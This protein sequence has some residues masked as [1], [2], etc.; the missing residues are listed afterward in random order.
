MTC[1]VDD[2]DGDRVVMPQ[3][4]HI[5]VDVSD[6]VATISITRAGRGNSLTT[7]TYLELRE[8]VRLAEVDDG[9]EIIVFS[10]E[11]R[12]FATGGDLDEA[13]VK[14]E[15]Q[16]ILAIHRGFDATPFAAIQ[17][18][19]KV[20]IA[21]VN[22]ICVAGGLMIAL[23]CDICIAAEDARFGIPEGRV[24]LA[25]PWFP[26][27]LEASPNPSLARFLMLSG[28]PFDVET[29]K[30]V[31]I[32]GESVAP[33]ALMT[34]VAELTAELRMTTVGARR[35]YKRFMNG[36]RPIVTTERLAHMM[37]EPDVIE[38]LR[39]AWG[40]RDRGRSERAP[41]GRQ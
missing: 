22:G 15:T 14:V 4:E 31:G 23:C 7:E 20:T 38:R 9:V 39:A 13:L 8:A 40:D 36:R 1:V 12:F 10:G 33:E 26:I 37:L 21:A 30:S 3:Y 2:P 17:N 27:L 5:A 32:V 28:K 16:D 18:S 25:D 6:G 35:R 19:E 41:G 24:G 11:G 34:R 29:A